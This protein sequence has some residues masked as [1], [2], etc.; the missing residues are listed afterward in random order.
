MP[1]ATPVPD[2]ILYCYTALIYRQHTYFHVHNRFLHLVS[3]LLWKTAKPT[4]R[5]YKKKRADLRKSIT[6]QRG[7]LNWCLQANITV[8]IPASVSSKET[9]VTVRRRDRFLLDRG[10]LGPGNVFQNRQR[11]MSPRQLLLR[12]TF[13][14]LIE[15]ERRPLSISWTS[16]AYY[17]G[18]HDVSRP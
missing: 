17:R 16:C 10:T 14:T 15:H 2:H 7:N 4:C 13:S 1:Q 8:P 5:I 12:R 18:S 3:A 6:R 9:V 11:G